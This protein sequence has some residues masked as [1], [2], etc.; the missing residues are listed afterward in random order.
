ML[1]LNGNNVGADGAAALAPALTRL[2]QLAHLSLSSNDVGSPGAAALAPALGRLTALTT[3]CVSNNNFSPDD[4]AHLAP[5][6]A[7]LP[8]LE[9][10]FLTTHVRGHWRRD[11]NP[12]AFRAWLPATGWKAKIF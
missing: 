10:L 1:H 8:H 3:L 4:M 5:A 11:P 2:S 6:L 12:A 7:R 9:S